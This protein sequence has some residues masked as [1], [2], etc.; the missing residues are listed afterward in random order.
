MTDGKKIALAGFRGFIGS[1]YVSHNR[2]STIIPISRDL[3]YGDPDKLGETMEGVD[4]V[5]NLAGSPIAGIWTPKNRKRIEQSRRDVNQNL[6]AALNGMENKPAHFVSAS[7]IGIY[8]TRGTHT[9]SSF[10]EGTGFLARVVRDWELPLEKLDAEI[11]GTLLR[12][13]I[14]LGRDGGALAPLKRVARFGM[15]PILGSG[16]QY[17]PFIHLEDL[18]RILDL[19]IRNRM[20]GIFNLCAPD[21]V[22]NATFTKTL[23]QSAHVRFTFRVPAFLLAAFLGEAHVMLTE[24]ARIVPERLLE[25]GFQFNYPDIGS[26]MEN[27]FQEH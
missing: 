27:L 4:V 16:D 3:L 10:T 2:A 21:T 24:G 9:E 14:V 11:T 1:G 18:F 12:I 7:A 13:G 23:A 25:T 22:D 20:G 17:M 19:V 15:L 8:D 6:V 5:L 26:A